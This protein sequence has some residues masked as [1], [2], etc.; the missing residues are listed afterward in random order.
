MIFDVETVTSLDACFA[1]YL[2]FNKSVGHW[3]QAVPAWDGD[4]FHPRKGYGAGVFDLWP[5]WCR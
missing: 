4:H 5:E 2:N 1:L 3:P